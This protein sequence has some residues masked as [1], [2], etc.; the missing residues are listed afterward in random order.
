MRF[1]LILIMLAGL[2]PAARAEG[3]SLSYLGHGRLVVNDLFGDRYDRWRTGSVAA[4]YV[5]GLGWNGTLPTRPGT[6]LEFRVQ[7]EVIAPARLDLA[8][9]GD[10]PYVQ[11][12]SFGLHTHFAL[13]GWDVAAGGDAVITGP[14]VGLIDFQHFLHRITQFDHM[15]SA[16]VRAA[17]IG[18]GVHGSAVIETGRDFTLGDGARFRPFVELRGG[19]E[20]MAR[21]GFDLAIGPAGQG[22][23]MVRDP[24]SG[25]RYRVLQGADDGV[26]LVIGGDLA[27][28][29]HSLYLPASRNRLSDLRARFRTGFHWQNDRWRGFYG[30]T[31]LG[32]EFK[33]QLESQLIGALRVQYDF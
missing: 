16:Q 8:W 28:V 5:F 18:N 1:L 29:T 11:A 4:S 30:M 17:Q 13:A 27:K 23:L 3:G 10:R 7:G 22:D 33:G 19:V 24:V 12:L 2:S 15:A 14:Q 20:E 25:F 26:T 21:I 9:Q 6:L 32:P 31:W